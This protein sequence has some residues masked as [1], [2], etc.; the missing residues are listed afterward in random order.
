[1]GATPTLPPNP[2]PTP[3]SRQGQTR[4]PGMD[5]DRD[6]A[7]N[8]D[9]PPATPAAPAADQELK[10]DLA[11]EETAA[12]LHHELAEAEPVTRTVEEPEPLGRRLP[13]P[14]TGREGVER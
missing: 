11:A 4:R 7:F 6:L 10:G 13:V 12:R 5:V 8:L 1:V 3:T 9:Q 2:Q 14:L